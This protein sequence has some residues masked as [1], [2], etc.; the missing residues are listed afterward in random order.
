MFGVYYPVLFYI[1]F[2]IIPVNID[3]FDPIAK[4]S[5]TLTPK[6]KN[7]NP[8]EVYLKTS[9][10]K[11]IPRKSRIANV[12]TIYKCLSVNSRIKRLKGADQSTWKGTKK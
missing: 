9:F 8:S 6:V 3:T 1:S 11:Q 2:L 5:D 7:S 10:F 4:Q 12:I